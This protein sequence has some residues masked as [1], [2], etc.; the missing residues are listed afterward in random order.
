[1]DRSIH[2]PQVSATDRH[3]ASGEQH[4]QPFGRTQLP[5][6]GRSAIAHPFRFLSTSAVPCTAPKYHAFAAN[7]SIAFP[8][9]H[10]SIQLTPL[11]VPVYPC[12]DSI[13]SVVPSPP[14]CTRIGI[15]LF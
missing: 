10:C 14:L 9:P 6:C 13:P 12:P 4:P 3:S 1:M 8:Y 5:S 11:P 2:K 15:H 7:H